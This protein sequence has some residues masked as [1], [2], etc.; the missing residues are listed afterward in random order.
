MPLGFVVFAAWA[1]IVMLTSKL[2]S[3]ESVSYGGWFRALGP[4]TVTN[5]LQLISVVGWALKPE[6]TTPFLESVALQLIPFVGWALSYLYWIVLTFV[7]VRTVARVS[8]LATIGI[9]LISAIG[10]FVVVGFLFA[11]LFTV[12]MMLA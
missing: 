1:G 7:A 4:I 9:M 6:T 2:F 12:W 3:S 11:L 8:R 10:P 5:L